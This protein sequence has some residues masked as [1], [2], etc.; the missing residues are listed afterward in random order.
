MSL[1]GV[2]EREGKETNDV[3]ADDDDGGG[4]RN[5][6]TETHRDCVCVCACVCARAT[7]GFRALPSQAGD[8][9]LRFTYFLRRCLTLVARPP[10]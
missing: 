9:K 10:L 2:G 1:R 4:E 7:D 8:V 6:D 5:K 3:G